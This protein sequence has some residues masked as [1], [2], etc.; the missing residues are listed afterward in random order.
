MLVTCLSQDPARHLQVRDN[1]ET[2][3]NDGAST[4]TH[5]LLAPA[6]PSPPR[7]PPIFVAGSG[8]EAYDGW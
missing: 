7:I 1:D 6:S 5:V 3:F 2:R 8:R 4:C